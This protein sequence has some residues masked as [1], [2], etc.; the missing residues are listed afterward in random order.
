MP[1]IEKS[2]FLCRA[3][4]RHFLMNDTGGWGF[5]KK[6]TKCD[7]GRRAVKNAILRMTHFLNDSE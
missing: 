4:V 1:Y 3:I 2:L 6:M 5:E 7:I